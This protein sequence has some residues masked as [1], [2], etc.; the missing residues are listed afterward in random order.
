[1]LTPCEVTAEL[2]L[3]RLPEFHAGGCATGTIRSYCVSAAWML[4]GS[5]VQGLDE[6]YVEVISASGIYEDTPETPE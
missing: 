3:R 4:F 2:G 5:R 1:M 6:P